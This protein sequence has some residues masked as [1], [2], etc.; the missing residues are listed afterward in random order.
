[1]QWVTWSQAAIGAVVCGLVAFAAARWRAA[2]PDGRRSIARVLDA[3]IPAAREL[4]F[5]AVIYAIWRVARTLPLTQDEGALERARTLARIQD[6][7]FLPTELSIQQWIVGHE[8]LVEWT[9]GY[10]A[11]VH[12]PSLIAFLVWLWV[13]HRDDYRHW[14]TGLALLTAACLVIRFFRVAPPRFLPEL[15]FVDLSERVGMNVYGPVGTGVSDQFAA[16]PSIHVGWAAVVA[17][18]VFRVSPSRWRWLIVLHLPVTMW[19]VAATGHHWWLDG[20]VA[21]VLLWAGLALDSRLRPALAGAGLAVPVSVFDGPA[22]STAASVPAG[23]TAP[24]LVPV[25]VKPPAE[26]G[27]SRRP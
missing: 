13:R 23:S 18:G 26:A 1:M 4:S 27:V 14:R 9:A 8:T 11:I 20:I 17:L 7:F 22:A 2:H 24:A 5:V 3:V 19:V 16:M 10:Y 12:V 25:P 21:L 15:G 6:W